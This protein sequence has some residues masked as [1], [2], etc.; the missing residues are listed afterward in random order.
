MT[1]AFVFG[2]GR[3][4][5]PYDVNI[6]RQYGTIIGCNNA[7]LDLDPDILVSVDKP[8][9]DIILDSN[10]N[11][12]FYIPKNIHD[13]FYFQRKDIK[14]FDT[15]CP[16][17]VDSGNF[18]LMIAAQT[19]K[20]IYMLGFDYISKN[21]FTNNVY[22]GFNNYKQK[23]QIHVLPE[24]EMNWYNKLA[25]TIARYDCQ[26]VRV[27]TNDYVPPTSWHNF[28]NISITEFL[29]LYPNSYDTAMSI[30]P[31]FTEEELLELKKPKISDHFNRM[32]NAPT[33]YIKK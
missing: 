30:G 31:G 16:G 23:H 3:S 17:I 12:D 21:R 33:I 19:H 24:S 11:N 9:I 28:K 14:Y 25:I 27:N 32:N 5:I 4:R 20:T 6:L 26:F 22:A 29:K 15:Q 2:N 10:Y 8:M 18:A 7:Y 13:Q 1:N